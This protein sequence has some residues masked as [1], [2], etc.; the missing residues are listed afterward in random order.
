LRA[1]S[2]LTDTRLTSVEG[3]VTSV[4][5][6]VTANQ[7][8]IEAIIGMMK[9]DR[10]RQ[11]R[12]RRSLP[13]PPRPAIM[14]PSAA[15]PRSTS[16][17]PRMKLITSGKE[18]SFGR[19]CGFWVPEFESSGS[20]SART[21]SGD[22]SAVAGGGAMV[23]SSSSSTL[24][25]PSS[26]SKP[27]KDALPSPSSLLQSRKESTSSMSG[28]GLVRCSDANAFIK[29]LESRG[30]TTLL[31]I[32]QSKGDTPADHLLTAAVN[33]VA[34]SPDNEAGA[35]VIACFDR[36]RSKSAF[37]PDQ[38]ST[39]RAA[40]NPENPAFKQ[41]CIRMDDYCSRS[42][43]KG[44]KFRGQVYPYAHL[45]QNDE[46]RKQLIAALRDT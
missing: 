11:D 8:G 24:P 21:S 42:P 15:S 41:F 12:E 2:K 4:E 36:A 43:G 1:E 29:D 22:K 18:G 10:E 32:L 45:A 6:K 31:G 17:Q 25:S 34:L 39:M 30:W 3:K 16:P 5:G 14:P 35:V 37:V 13:E 40:F 33:A 9:E 28:S 19:E 20:T 27:K 26:L 23:V 46:H 38:Q 44:I 7:S